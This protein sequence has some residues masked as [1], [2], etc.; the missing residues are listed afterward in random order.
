VLA[1]IIP[2]VLLAYLVA[3][4]CGVWS[5]TLAGAPRTRY[6]DAEALVLAR[7]AGLT[8]AS[9]P[10]RASAEVSL[11]S[12]FGK[13]VE[14]TVVRHWSNGRYAGRAW[15]D[16]QLG[17]PM[18]AFRYHEFSPYGT[19]LTSGWPVPGQWTKALGLG[20]RRVILPRAVVPLGFAANTGLN[21]LIFVIVIRGGER[22]RRLIRGWR[23]RCRACDYDRRG[24]G[25]AVA[26]PECGSLP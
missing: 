15:D 5:P 22:I 17:W 20:Y 21:V 12:G 3:L 10:G 19:G 25:P 18:F 4:A 24:L 9:A 7:Q 14:T 1:Y 16:T 6:S 2:A 8:S 13:R 23:A 11:D 26:C